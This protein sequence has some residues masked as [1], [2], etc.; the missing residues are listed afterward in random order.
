MDESAAKRVAEDRATFWNSKKKGR[1]G[2]YREPRTGEPEHDPARRSSMTCA[3][4]PRPRRCGRSPGRFDTP[5][6][7]GGF[8]SSVAARCARLFAALSLLAA[9]S[10]QAQPADAALSGL[11]VEVSTDGTTFRSIV[12][13]P[14]F[15]AERRSYDTVVSTDHTHVRV[16]PTIQVGVG[17][18]VGK[19]GSLAPVASGSTSA[20]ITLTTGANQIRIRVAAADGRNFRM[21]Y[22]TVTRGGQVI[23]SSLRSVRASTGDAKLILAWQ[24]PVLWGS[25][26]AGGYEVDWYAGS[27]PPTDES[28]WERA[29]PTPQPLAATATRYEFTGTYAGHTVANGTTYQLRVRGFGTNPVDSSDTLPSEWTTVSGTPQ[30]GATLST[31]ANLSGLTAATGTSAGSVFTGLT[32]T[33]STFSAST[34][35]Y[36]ASVA[37]ERTHLKLTPTVA[38]T[39][40]ATVT[41]DGSSVASGSAS[42][43][44]ALSVG[45]NAITVRVTAEDGITT[46]DYTVTVTRGAPRS[47]NANLSGLTASSAASSGGPF[48]TLNIGT[49]AAM[50]TSYT[51]SV[52]NARTH[53]KLT[54]T[55]AD[56]GKATVTVD[57][58][59]VTSGSASDAIALS[60]GSNAITVRVTAEDGSTTKDYTVTVTRGA[61]PRS[62]NANLS[63]LTASSAASSGG[64]FATLNIGAFRAATTSY[65]ASVA[66]A[67]THLKLTPTVADTGKATVTVDGN[68]VDSGTASGPV[69]LVVGANA[70]VVRVTAEDTTTTK[71]Y[72]VTVTRAPPPS[73]D[74]TLSGLAASSATSSGG[75][76]ATLDIGAFSAGTASYAATVANA[77]THVKLTPTVNHGSATVT[78]QGSPVSSGSPSAAIALNT[79]SNA[80]TVRVTAQDSSTRDYTVTITRQAQAALPAVTLS[81]SPNP[82]A[83]GSSVTVTARLSQ[84]L[85]GAV[86]IPL[87]ITDGTAEPADHGTL[88]SITIASGATSGTGTIATNQDPDEEDETFTVA[89]G[90]LP[91]SVAAGTPGSVEVRIA[92]DE[93]IPTVTL[94]VAPNPVREGSEARLTATLSEPTPPSRILNVPLVYGHV[95][96]EQLDFRGAGEVLILF[97]STTGSTPIVA[98]RD[99]DADDETFTVAV[100]ETRLPS[101]VRAGSPASVEVTI[102]DDGRPGN[103]QQD[104]P[105]PPPPAE[106]PPPPP[107]PPPAGGGG[108][109]G[110][111]PG[112]DEQGGDG[113]ANRAPETAGIAGRTLRAGTE[114]EIDL[115]DAFDDPDGDALTYAAES[116]AEAVATVEVDGDTLTVR[117]IRRGTA[118][119][120]VTATDSGGRTVSTTFEATV[121]GP[122]TAWYLPPASDTLRQGFVRVLNH[123]DAAGEASIAATDDAGARYE[124]LTL[125]LG[126]R[127][128]MHFHTGDLESGNPAK[129]LTGATGM[130]A[131]GW[132]LAIES[133]TLDVE[134]LAYVRTDDGFLAGLNDVAPLEDGTLEIPIFNP[135]SNVDQVSLLRLVNPGDEEAEATVTGTDDA[136]LSPGSP[137]VLTLPAGTACMVDAAQLES[138]TGLACGSPQD[139]LGDGAGKWRLAI[140]SD[141]RLV[142]MSLLSSPG[143]HLA[144]LSGKAT[145]DWENLWHMHLFP[146]ASDPLGRQ[147]VVRA[148]NRTAGRRTA[149]VLAYDDSNTRYDTLRLALGVGQTVHF[150]S[151]DLELGNRA[152]GLSGRTGA[153][154]GTWRLT[155]YGL[156]EAHAYVRTTDGFLAAMNAMAPR[157]R[158]VH[159]VAFFNPGTNR[160]TSVLRLVNRSS[161]KAE[162]SIDGTDDLGLRPGTTVRVLVPATDAVEL[163]AAQ[164]ESGEHGAI[165]SGALGDGTGKWRL[166][167]ESTRLAAVLSLLSSPSG[168]LT[169]LSRADGT[170]GLGDLP[171]ALLPAPATVTLESADDGEIRGRWSAV[172]GARYDVDLLK[173]GVRD[174]LRSQERAQ[175]TSFLWTSTRAGTYTIRVRSVNAD[176]VAGPWSTVSNEVAID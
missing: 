119:V 166:R 81:A 77:R 114:V 58:N 15:S 148:V 146:A 9:A 25:Y 10:A 127:A 44:I 108:G 141:R 57:G 122:E 134:A 163:T 160:R 34:T 113:S 24:E 18:T 50:T 36:T 61:A 60:V 69:A 142:A 47:T 83:E 3:G 43:P 66:N 124:P 128:A 7:R 153:G 16:T 169:N 35:A 156:G 49:F 112:D 176:G 4:R 118:E 144:N 62:T 105:P 96:S 121:T 150:D 68:A 79:G 123:S 129:G 106:D 109:G 126:P 97:S 37:N 168:H 2:V 75:P 29:T 91:A 171:A 22:L 73:S 152:K 143:G 39:G 21:Y 30:S 19:E 99:A 162:V 85:S 154:R 92:D 13:L 115:S 12:Y 40:K 65:T 95:T 164:L 72:T 173:D 159:R 1:H 103:D 135:A 165:E 87:T 104:P 158:S 33:P 151:D 20:P 23:P 52:A 133:E 100:D 107:P 136:G 157:A 59:A 98:V 145:P 8:A 78:V 53:L 147:G 41:V 51:A 28:D 27:S 130:G 11:A 137:V 94:S 14:E 84:A 76:Y 46:E 86:T 170:R 17:V 167:V 110:A 102:I 111:G 101:W 56:T 5:P 89:L 117:G 140:E 172:E 93:G 88:A 54:P 125:A 31:N 6:W 82:V 67:R 48:A 161:R 149:T 32:L 74:A 64:P 80:I 63:G 26:P 45:S 71:D 139:G 90:A 174:E 55:V 132:R 138:G 116:S 70:I 120:T 38:D 175:G 155:L 42:G 131:G